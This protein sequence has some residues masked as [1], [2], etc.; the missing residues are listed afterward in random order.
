MHHGS[1]GLGAGRQVLSVGLTEDAVLVVLLNT[2]TAVIDLS[3]SFYNNQSAVWFINSISDTKILSS[4]NIHISDFRLKDYSHKLSKQ[5]SINAMIT[6]KSLDSH[7]CSFRCFK[8]L[9][10]KSFS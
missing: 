6:N 3:D 10:T 5:L 2:R 8:T 9:K 4:E 1:I 7:K